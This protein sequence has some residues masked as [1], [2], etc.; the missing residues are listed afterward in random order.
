M[1]YV[2]K[3][4]VSRR[5]RILARLRFAI[6]AVNEDFSDERILELT[7]GTLMRA[8]IEFQVDKDRL[9]EAL[10]AQCM[11]AKLLLRFY[12]TD[13]AGYHQR[14]VGEMG[15]RSHSPS[16]NAYDRRK[17]WRHPVRHSRTHLWCPVFVP[18]VTT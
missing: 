6:Y 7:R 16:G 9:K 3:R 1:T 5:A 11:E 4:S 17:Y 14:V 8:R 13:K 18:R 2:S 12:I 10:R 15:L